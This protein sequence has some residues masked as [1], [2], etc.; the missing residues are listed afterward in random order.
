M[1][2]RAC[3]TPIWMSRAKACASGRKSRVLAPAL[4]RFGSTGTALA[5]SAYMLR[6]VSTQPLGRPV[7][8]LV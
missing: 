8:P 7:V 6:W 2:A 3:T 5:M 1:V 4:N